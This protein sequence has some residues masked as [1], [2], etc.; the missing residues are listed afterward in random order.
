MVTGSNLC[1]KWLNTSTHEIKAWSK[2]PFIFLFIA[3]DPQETPHLQEIVT[4]KSKAWDGG[5]FL[6]GLDWDYFCV[7]ILAL[8][9]SIDLLT[10]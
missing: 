9:Y 1:S 10:L 3:T 2:L 5:G 8:P 4:Q 6:L 7:R